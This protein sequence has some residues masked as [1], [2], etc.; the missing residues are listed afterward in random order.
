MKGTN[1][2]CPPIAL[3]I[4]SYSSSVPMPIPY[5]MHPCALYPRLHMPLR[6]SVLCA[7]FCPMIPICTYDS[8]IGRSNGALVMQAPSWFKFLAKTLPNNRFSYQPEKS[9]NFW[10]CHFLLH[11]LCP[12]DSIPSPMSLLCPYKLSMVPF[13]IG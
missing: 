7:P 3:L 11:L 10:I 6:L 13:V 12:H 4:S 1:H 9:L 5:P 2:M 8:S